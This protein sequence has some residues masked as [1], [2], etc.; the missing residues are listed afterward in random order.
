VAVIS[1]SAWQRRFNGASVIGKQLALNGIPFTV[2]GVGPANFRGTAQ[3]AQEFDVIVPMSTYDSVNRSTQA[4][5]P[6]Y[7]WILVMARLHSGVRLEQV[8]PAADLI[9]KR[10]TAEA[11]PQLTPADLPRVALEPGNR[12]QTE[13]RDSVR[14]PLT[15]M[16]LV[17]GI[18]LL[19]ACANVANLLLARGRARVKELTVRVAI[20]AGRARVVRQLV[21]EGLVLAVGGG[22]V[23]LLLARFVAVALLPALTGSPSILEDTALYW[24]VGLFT[25]A[26]AMGC[27]LLFGVIPALRAT[28]LHLAS[29]L[30]EATRASTATRH[31]S[32]LA[33]ALVAIQVALSIVLVTAS[34]LL[35]SSLRGLE[36]VDPGFNPENVLTFRLDPVQN[37]YQG[38]RARLLIENALARLRAI[39]GVRAASFSSHGLIS[40]QSDATA[41]RPAG[42]PSPESGGPGA[43]E[44]I[45]SHRAWRLIVDEEFLPTI[46]IPLRSGR[47]LRA[48]D[49]EGTLPVAVINESLAKQL[50][51]TTDVLNRRFAVALGP[52]SPVFE[53]VGVSAD[54]KYTSLRRPAPP[55]LY[56]SYRQR[57][58]FGT[59]FV[60]RTSLEPMPIAEQVRTTI[61]ALDPTLAI[62]NLRTQRE[63]IE[64][65][66]RR[67]RLFARLATLL[68]G[69]TL[70][71]AMIGLYGSLTYS[72]TRR[73]P[74][75]G[76][77]MALGA[78]RSSVR[79][80]V[81]KQSL[82]LVATGL[83]IGIPAA[84]GGSRFVS[85]LLFNISPTSPLA[86]V[87]AAGIM[88]GVS[89]IAAF[90]PAHRASRVDPMVALRAE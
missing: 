59:T 2:I 9:V 55:T 69:V 61:G 23:G 15:T 1:H 65:S 8:R 87:V 38:P 42:A 44:F 68:G 11:R 80:M 13:S 24:R 26:A 4:A 36:G 70:L 79:R 25:M 74:E 21:T 28:D 35:V 72:V 82:A 30:Q 49:T 56:V 60:V 29:G 71:L 43:Q 12:G 63:Q 14:E 5:S 77:R 66:L 90:V 57:A 41:A 75:L 37:G 76:L 45:A 78:D 86:L 46:G 62:S 34:A 27:T 32:P 10:T 39:P 47:H 84:I 17:V 53:I 73:T 58:A 64:V 33:G 51:G 81:L 31:R 20:G 85:S 83:A 18:V 67:E 3:V 50:F 6:N 19:V 52:K 16:A 88:L 22:L 89:L 40:G 48:S 54:A 7:W